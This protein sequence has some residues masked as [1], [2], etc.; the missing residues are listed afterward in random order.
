LPSRALTHGIPPSRS[1]K[2]P[3]LALLKSRVAILFIALLPPRR[4]LNSTISCMG[5]AVAIPQG[6]Y[7]QVVPCNSL[8]LRGVDII[9]RVI[10]SNYLEEVKV[11]IRYTGS[12]PLRCMQ[13]D[14]RAQV[15]CERIGVP[16]IQE[17]D[18]LQPAQ[19]PGGFGSTGCVVWV[20]NP[21]K[22]E[23]LE[24]EI[25]ADGPGDTHLVI[26]KG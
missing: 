11:V 1:L 4:I 10:D 9:A 22:P 23:Q 24:G 14:Q 7:G 25:T 5:L 6:Y 2:R 12:Q 3:K 19:Q 18:S 16:T 21:T 26:I 13:G 20:H 17:V 8:S 15:I